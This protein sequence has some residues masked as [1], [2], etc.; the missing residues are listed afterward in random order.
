MWIVIKKNGGGFGGSEEKVNLV[1]KGDMTGMTSKAD[2]AGQ[3]N[4]CDSEKTKDEEGVL[5]DSDDIYDGCLVTMSPLPLK[6]RVPM[7]CDECLV[8][9]PVVRSLILVLS[10][11]DTIKKEKDGSQAIKRN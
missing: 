2:F 3:M 5:D 4:Q 9:I 10:D 6:T 11:K 1:L 7:S 8:V